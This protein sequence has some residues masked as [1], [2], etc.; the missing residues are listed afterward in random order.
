[1]IQ[2]RLNNTLSQV[3]GRTPNEVA[4]GF[5]I[6]DSLDLSGH[7]PQQINPHIAR[8]EVQ[9]AINWAQMNQKFHYDRKHHPQFLRRDD[10]ALLRLHKGYDIPA[11]KAL[12]RKIGQQYVR[13]F[14]VLER[15]DRLAYKLNL[16]EDWRIHNV[17]I[18]AQLKPCSNPAIDP[19]NR[20]RPTNPR[21]VNAK[22]DDLPPEWDVTRILDSRVTA[23][24]RTQYLIRWEGY[25]AQADRWINEEDIFADD[26][27][28]EYKAHQDQLPER[29]I[30]RRRLARGSTRP[31]RRNPDPAS[32]RPNPAIN[33]PDPMTNNVVLRR[34]NRPRRIRTRDH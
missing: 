34:S 15:I 31:S 26:L 8:M 3:I 22:R 25:E 5:T 29:Q 17:F 1:M 21:P 6:N 10:Y 2:F 23:R 27:I 33:P 7:E 28:Q 19:F 32:D 16:P 12:K 20:P 24:G 11:N 14:R 30:P 4:S 9:D 13:P 18:I